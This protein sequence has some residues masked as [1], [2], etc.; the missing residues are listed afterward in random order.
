LVLNLIPLPPLD[1]SGALPLILPPEWNHAYQRL[2]RQPMIG[3][4]GIIVVWNLLGVIFY[5][6]L[7][8]SLSLLYPGLTYS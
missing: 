2:L 7:F 6:I 8:F 5:P 1:G 4:L 3:L